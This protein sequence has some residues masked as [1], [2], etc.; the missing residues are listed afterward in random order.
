MDIA[1]WTIDRSR[2]ATLED[3]VHH[4]LAMLFASTHQLPVVSQQVAAEP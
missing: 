3:L 1:Q 4:V 2:K